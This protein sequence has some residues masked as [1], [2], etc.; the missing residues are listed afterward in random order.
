MADSWARELFALPATTTL[1]VR[2][3]DSGFVTTVDP[4]ADAVAVAE[5]YARVERPVTVGVAVAIGVLGGA[6]VIALP[7]LWGLAVALGL[8]ALARVPVFQSGGRTRLRTDADPATVREAFVGPTPPPLAL[9][10]GVADEV[11]VDGEDTV[12]DVSYLFGL[13]S[14]EMRVD[15]EAVDD[16]VELTVTTDGQAWGTYTARIEPTV[17][18]TEI[19]VEIDSDR[20]F[21]L[22]RL[23]QHLVARRDRDAATEVQGYEVVERSFSLSR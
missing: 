20:K 12:Y 2:A 15:A 9:Q 19:T 14:V 18:G 3:I 21:G 1:T 11:R 8:L 23:P 10:W 17:D 6:A 7:L 5:R 16:R 13:R 4:P 22:R